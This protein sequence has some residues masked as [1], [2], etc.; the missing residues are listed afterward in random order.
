M[1]LWNLVLIDGVD[2]ICCLKKGIIYHPPEFMKCVMYRFN[3]QV[4]VLTYIKEYEL[5]SWLQMTCNCQFKNNIF[6]GQ[7]HTDD[8]YF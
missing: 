4:P 5:W 1:M 2:Q 3:F 6:Q 8:I 7:L